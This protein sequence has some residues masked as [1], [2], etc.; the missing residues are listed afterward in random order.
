MNGSEDDEVPNL[1]AISYYL[2]MAPPFTDQ[3]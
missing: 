2:A 1:I 3:M